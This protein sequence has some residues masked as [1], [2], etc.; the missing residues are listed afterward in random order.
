MWV[1]RSDRDEVDVLSMGEAVGVD[2]NRVARLGIGRERGEVDR[3]L[4][5]ISHNITAP[6][7]RV[8]PI[9]SR[10]DDRPFGVAARALLSAGAG[11]FAEL[12]PVVPMPLVVVGRR[13]DGVGVAGITLRGIALHKRNITRN[14]ASATGHRDVREM[15]A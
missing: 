11:G 10:A 4:T 14:G 15:L 2:A 13:T 9:V 7:N 6:K 5:L 1:P 8:S 3:V 12:D